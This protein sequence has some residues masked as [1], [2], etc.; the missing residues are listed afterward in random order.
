MLIL[1]CRKN[2]KTSNQL[3]TLGWH[4]QNLETP[5]ENNQSWKLSNC[6]FV[7]GKTPLEVHKVLLT[8]RDQKTTMATFEVEINVNQNVEES[9]NFYKTLRSMC[10]M[11]VKS[12]YA[13]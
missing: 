13:W 8:N 2:E 10:G 9:C 12:D 1:Y 11:T 7:D 4:T 6:C 3:R 5:Q